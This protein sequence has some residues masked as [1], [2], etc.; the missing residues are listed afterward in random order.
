MERKT[1][2][3]L[4]F[5]AG[6]LAIMGATA[7]MAV[8]R[9]KTIPDGVRAIRPF[10]ADRFLGRWYE[11]ARFDY[12][13]ERGLTH[14]SAEYSRNPDGSI[15]VVNRGRKKSGKEVKATG[16]A[17]FVTEPDVAM[18]KVSFFGPFYAGYNVIA[19]DPDYQ[20]A[21]VA[22]QSRDY[23]W[24][25]SREKKIPEA[26]KAQYL[27]KARALGFEVDKLVWPEQEAISVP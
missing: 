12:R 27:E 22:G 9:R 24:M 7:T 17:L 2:R 8:A 15:R 13:F 10:D 19:L 18:L 25:L 26:M 1:A 16:R 4:L 6:A 23:L 14:T 21:L 11:I 3:V 5:S 20:Y